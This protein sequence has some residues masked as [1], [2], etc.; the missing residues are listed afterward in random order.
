MTKGH[1][2]KKLEEQSSVLRA[3]SNQVCDIN[4]TSDNP[5]CKTLINL[6]L[7]QMVLKNF[8]EASVPIKLVKKAHDRQQNRITL[9]K[10]SQVTISG[11]ME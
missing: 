11:Q 4:V 7:L 8:S 9:N 10:N 6:D 2:W 3:L 1:E 5:I